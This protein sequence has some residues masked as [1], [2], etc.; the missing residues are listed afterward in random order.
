MRRRR[1]RSSWRLAGSPN[2]GKSSVFNPL[3]GLSQHVGN[4][5]GKTVELKAGTCRHK[6]RIF[7]IVD[8]PG[9]YS[10]T[11]NS[12]RSRLHAIMSCERTPRRSRG[13]R[14]R[15]QPGAHLLPRR[16]AARAARAGGRGREHDGCGRAARA[17]TWRSTSCRRPWACPWSPWSPRGNEGLQALLA[18]AIEQVVDG[19]F[20]YAPRRPELGPEVEGA[21]RPDR[22]T[23]RRRRPPTLPPAL[24]G[25][26]APGGRQRGHRPP[27]CPHLSG[28]RWAQ[29]DALLRQSEDA[30]LTIAGA[31]YEW[32]G[33]MVRAAVRRPRAGAIS[34][35]ERLDRV[36]THIY[37]GPLVLLGLLGAHLL[38]RLPG[39]PARSWACSKR[40]SGC[41]A[42]CD[43]ALARQR[44]RLAQRPAGRWR[45]RRRGHGAHPPA[46][47]GPFLRRHRLPGGCWL[48]RPRRLCGRP[49]YAP[50]GPARQVVPAALPGLWLQRARRAGG[51]HPRLHGATACSPPCSCRSCPAPG[52]WRCSSSSRAPSLAAMGRW[53]RW[54]CSRFALGVMAAS[55]ALLNRLLFQGESPAF[56]MELPLYHLPNWRTIGLHTWRHVVDFVVAGGHGDPA[57]LGRS[58]G[59]WPVCPA[60]ASSRAIWPGSAAGSRPWAA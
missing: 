41:A 55:G 45:P 29:V 26:K 22:A 37:A 51:A 24:A 12:A 23:D 11:A 16:R 54:R 57:P 17:C 6:G 60:A 10:L 15:R 53:S 7:E 56:I 43:A 31:R 48:P 20:D 44:P 9:T 28:E 50:H 59:P 14:Q 40:R 32:I 2:V 3:T 5:A 27:A 1:G 47:A 52:A 25:A 13:H 35:T 42:E 4:W 34:L 33:R 38:V 49:L 18:A 58:S 30:V 46:H 36:A 21:R 8:L 39:S 19:A